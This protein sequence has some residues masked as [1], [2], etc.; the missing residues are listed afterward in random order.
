MHASEVDDTD[1][2]L[3]V[4]D[5]VHHAVDPDMDAQHVGAAEGALRPRFVGET[6]DCGEH[7]PHAVGVVLGEPLRLG[8][9]LGLPD[10][11]VAHASFPPNTRR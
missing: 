5:L 2:D 11:L 1:A 9:C 10:D 4:A 8:E 3:L 6:V 7:L